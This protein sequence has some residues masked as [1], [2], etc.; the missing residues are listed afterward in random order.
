MVKGSVPSSII[1]VK[2]NVMMRPAQIEAWAVKIID[3]VR[4]GKPI[5]DARVELKATWIAPEKAARRIAGHANAARGAPILWLIGLDEQYGVV[6]VDHGRFLS[7]Y[8]QVQACFDGVA[9][10]VVDLAI[11]VDGASVVVLFFNT[12]RVPFLVQNPVFGLAGGGPVQWEVPWREGT[13]IRSADRQALLKLLAPLQPRPV[14]ELLRGELTA[15]LTGSK[16][17]GVL[18]RLSLDLYNLS[19]DEGR[20]VIPFHKCQGAFQIG[21][22]GAWVKFETLEIKPPYPL[23]KDASRV[24]AQSSLTIQGT[25]DEVFI[26]GP[27]KMVLEAQTEIPMLELSGDEVVH[28]SI[29]LVVINADFPIKLSLDLMADGS[30]GGTDNM[31]RWV[32]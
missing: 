23:P 13:A 32:L 27:G 26:S 12:D 10:S 30:L 1:R 17:S 19:V 22:H 5:E 15:A 6:G 31:W 25:S 2:E 8:A 4:E 3:R 9:P 7:W 24:T 14:L 29:T 11:P 20:M 18:W 21:A 28:V 16:T